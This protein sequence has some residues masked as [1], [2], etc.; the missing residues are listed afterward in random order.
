MLT[1]I[2]GSVIFAAGFLL[3]LAWWRISLPKRQ[4]KVLLMLFFAVL[5]LSLA[6]LAAAPDIFALEPVCGWE[7]FHIALYVT[8]LVLAYMITY[9]AIEADSPSL[10]LALAVA[11]CGAK[12]MSS[13]E[14]YSL[15]DDRALVDPRL[16]DLLL[17]KMAAL[18]NGRYVITAKGR[19][20][21]NIFM[22]HRSLLGAG[23]GG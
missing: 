17:D 3:H 11:R 5:L 2:F 22:L 10:L 1:L 21:A 8:A 19:L 9:S 7:L 16:A 14:I 6:A 12:G 4:T 15:L 18:E 20:F 23:K 13:G